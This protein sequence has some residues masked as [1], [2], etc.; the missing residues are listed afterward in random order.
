M[1]LCWAD[2]QSTRELF[3]REIN[4]VLNAKCIPCSSVSPAEGMGPA[5]DPT[6]RQRQSIKPFILLMEVIEI[7]SLLSSS[8]LLIV[9][10][11]Y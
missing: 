2:V 10:H 8:N 1:L 4:G 3:H 9:H 5:V 7:W 11:S 6:H